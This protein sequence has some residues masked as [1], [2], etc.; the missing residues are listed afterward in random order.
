MRAPQV[1]LPWANVFDDP[2]GNVH[3]CVRADWHVFVYMRVR[4]NIKSANATTTARTYTYDELPLRL[5]SHIIV[6]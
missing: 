5:P 6:H 4:G 1:G 3:S 2:T